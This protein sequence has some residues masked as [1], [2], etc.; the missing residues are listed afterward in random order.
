MTS[1]VEFTAGHYRA[2][3]ELADA[4]IAQFAEE[5]GTRFEALAVEQFALGALF[6]LGRLRELRARQAALLAEATAAGDAYYCAVLRLGVSN[7]TLWLSTDQAARSAADVSD[8]E[9]I[10]ARDQHDFIASQ[11]AQAR[12]EH[13]IYVGD[14]AL[15]YRLCNATWRRAQQVRLLDIAYV[16]ELSLDGRGRA[17]I[18]AIS[19]RLDASDR[20]K[21]MASA[22]RDARA[23][24]R[25]KSATAA[26][27]AAVLR[28]G[29]AG[30]G[31]EVAE[32]RQRLTEAAIGFDAV[33]MGLHAAS[34]R[35]QLGAIDGGEEGR[36]LVEAADAAL[37]AQG[38]TRPD[39]WA[40]L[41]APM[42]SNAQRRG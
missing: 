12:I 17:A 8:G 22:R 3:L 31:G 38:V 26:P 37:H 27:R 18:T 39:R 9:A 5:P 40:Q 13:A 21:K 30:A 2:C 6:H 14:G 29:I 42:A 35:R 19:G 24:E 41:I 7:M 20:A 15:A 33:E 23:L 1:M 25:M 11:A 36:A 10:W 34:V 4:A 32:A 16:R 28:A